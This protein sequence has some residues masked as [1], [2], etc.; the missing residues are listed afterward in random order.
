MRHG[1]NY[2]AI[3]LIFSRYVDSSSG[4]PESSFRNVKISFYANIKQ[5]R[6][7]QRDND[8]PMTLVWNGSLNSVLYF[9]TELPECCF[10]YTHYFVLNFPQVSTSVE[11]EIIS[12]C[13]ACEQVS[14]KWKSFFFLKTLFHSF[15]GKWESDEKDMLKV[16]QKWVSDRHRLKFSFSKIFRTVR[17]KIRIWLAIPGSGFGIY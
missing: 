3:A 4:L 14:M 12:S 2:Y 15:L 8:K 5:K 17:N 11:N 9:S 1:S 16:K 10:F 6:V 13:D 7:W